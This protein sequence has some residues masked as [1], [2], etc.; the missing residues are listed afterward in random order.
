[1]INILFS[2]IDKENG[3]NDKQIDCIKRYVK[4][5]SNIV[6]ISSI[7]NNYNRNDEQLNKIF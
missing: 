5:C 2:G 1:M 7:F 6:L 3:F 4:N